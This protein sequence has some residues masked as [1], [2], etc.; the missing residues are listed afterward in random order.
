MSFQ[1]MPAYD[2]YSAARAEF[3]WNLPEQYNPAVD[4]VRKHD[5]T[6]TAL[7]YVD[8]DGSITTY[9]YGKLDALSDRLAAALRTKG[10]EQGDRIAVVAP[11][12]PET[13]VTHLAAWKL[14]AISVPLTVLFGPEALQYRIAD[15]GATAVVVDPQRRNT[16]D[17]ITPECPAVASVIELGESAAGEA[18]AFEALLAAHEPRFE[19]I[20]STP[21]TPSAIMY[22]SGSTGRP[23]GVKHSH[24]LWLGR[25]AAAE[26]YFEGVAEEMLW[27]PA[28]WAWG[29]ALGGTVAAGLHYGATVVA[30]PREAFEPTAIFEF[31]SRH[32]VTKTFM[33]PTALRMLQTVDTPPTDLSLKTIAAAGEPLTPELLQWAEETLSVPINEFYGQTE[34]NLCVGNCAAWFDP[35]PGSMGRVLPGYAVAVCDPEAPDPTNPLPP[36]TA[37]ELLV[38]AADRRVVFDGY[39]NSPEQTAAKEVGD[40]WFRTGDIVRRDEAGRLWFVSRADDII[41]TSGYR[42]GPTEIEQVLTS[43]P[44][45]EQVGVI[46]VDDEKRGEAIKAFVQVVDGDAGNDELRD[47]L[48]D[49]VRQRLAEYQYPRAIEFVESLPTTTTGKIQR[50]TLRAWENS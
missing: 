46:G 13:L 10:I 37:G 50:E 21:A 20:A 6:R 41:L 48:R 19:P 8:S 38:R 2:S 12:K 45:V 16:V 32:E 9:S 44:S 28:D 25:A 5:P 31:L 42:V 49:R 22:T 23:K 26:I 27:T 18:D 39:W 14:G 40:G 36:E 17:E 43:H 15:S 29:A 33:P 47:A 34:L 11:Q 24:G 35:K 3:A 4:F 1:I 7:R 30:W